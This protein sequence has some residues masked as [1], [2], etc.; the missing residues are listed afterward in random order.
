MVILLGSIGGQ[1]AASEHWV[2]MAGAASASLLWFFGLAFGA[3]KLA[4]A[5]ARP[6]AWRLLDGLVCLVMWAIA[7]SLI[8]RANG[9]W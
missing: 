9:A 7:A 5:F 3:S 2:F 1:F 4:P 8:A 6:V